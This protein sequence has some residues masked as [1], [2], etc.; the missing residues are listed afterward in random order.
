[1]IY[2]VHVHVSL[3]HQSVYMYV[4]IWIMTYLIKNFQIANVV[5]TSR[6]GLQRSALDCKSNTVL[7]GG[8]KTK[9]IFRHL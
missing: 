5:L 4:K 6:Y 3:T 9:P 7:E 2:C 1:M 8:S